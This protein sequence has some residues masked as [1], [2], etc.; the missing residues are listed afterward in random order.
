V[1]PIPMVNTT[2]PTGPLTIVTDRCDNQ[3]VIPVSKIDHWYEEY[4]PQSGEIPQYA[5][6]IGSFEAIEFT[7]W[8]WRK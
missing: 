6:Y 5:V 4:V 3:Y 1:K 7:E 2:K 8:G